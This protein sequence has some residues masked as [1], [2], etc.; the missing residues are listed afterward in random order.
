M[1]HNNAKTESNWPT[2]GWLTSSPEEQGMDSARLNELSDYLKGSFPNFYNYTVIKNGYNIFELHNDHPYE[3]IGSRML[4]KSLRT[5]LRVMNKPEYLCIDQYRGYYNLRSATKSIMSIL[6]GIA[7][8]KQIID[9]IDEKVYK[10]LPEEYSR[11][12]NTAKEEITLRHLITMK[13]GLKSIERGL[14]AIKM[15]F[16]DGDWVKY[17]LQLPMESRPGENFSYNSANTHLLSAVLCHVTN[18]STLDFAQKYLFEPLGIKDVFW[19]EDD[20]GYN[21]GGGNLFLSQYDM[22]KIGYLYLNKGVWDNKVIVSN[23]WVAA[24]LQNY[25]DWIYGFQYGYLWYIKNESC[26]GHVKEY[27]TYSAAGAG[28]QR[29]YIIPDLNIVIA[30]ASRTSLT[31][32][33]SYLLNNTIS[34]FILPAVL[35]YDK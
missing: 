27:I 14:S 12:F 5:A 23:K 17:I 4:K 35:I 6:L 22:A 1:N 28:G 21:F 30:A 10:L 19:E 34:E 20:K 2:N 18:M 29:I 13:S 31:G 9:G 8:D 33:K 32:D 11:Y 26:K 25:H 7:L 3:N 24:S 15:L 16:S